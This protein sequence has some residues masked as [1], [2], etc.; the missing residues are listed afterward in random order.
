M[1]E[2]KDVCGQ[3]EERAA[4][5]SLRLFRVEVHTIIRLV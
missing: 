5:F 2:I 3:T 1:S 4:T